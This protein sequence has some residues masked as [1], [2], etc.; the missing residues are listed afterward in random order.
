MAQRIAVI[1]AGAVGRGLAGALARGGADVV[2]GARSGADGTVPVSEAIAGADVVVVAVPGAAVPAFAAEHG[3]ALDGRVVLDATNDTSGEVMHHMDDWERA[4]PGALVFR[5]F[6]TLGWENV[7]DPDLPGGP[8]DLLYCGPVQ[9]CA[10]AEEAIA[11][12]GLRPVWI[13][14]PEDAD[15]LDGLTR[16][17]FTLAFARGRGRRLAFR[18]LEAGGA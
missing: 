10:V 4:A 17:W 3:A 8:P 18:V 9:A 6:N 12:T 11:A 14:G 5:A 16:L 7:A 1:G 13:G 15:L 2:I